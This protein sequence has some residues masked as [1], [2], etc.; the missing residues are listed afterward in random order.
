M[1][2]NLLVITQDFMRWI[3]SVTC[4]SSV[5]QPGKMSNCLGFSLEFLSGQCQR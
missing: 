3:F 2:R 5:V 1:T 4:I